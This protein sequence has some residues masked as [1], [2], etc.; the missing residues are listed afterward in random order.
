[1][2][3]DLAIAQIATNSV[4]VVLPAGI[5]PPIIVQYNASSVPVLQIALSSDTLGGSNSTIM[6]S[7][8]CGSGWRRSTA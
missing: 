1:V 8:T 2:N 7:T 4:R 3:L 5:Q 6:A